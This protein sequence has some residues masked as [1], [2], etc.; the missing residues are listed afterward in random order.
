MRVDDVA[1]NLYRHWML[2]VSQETSTRGFECVSMT[3]RAISAEP[4]WMRRV[5]TV[6]S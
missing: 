5:L 6:C 2:V 4:K 3:W 1:N